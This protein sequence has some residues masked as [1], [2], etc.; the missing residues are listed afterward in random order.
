ML[1]IGQILL[2]GLLVLLDVLLVGY[3]LGIVSVFRKH[4]NSSFAE[5]LIA[6]LAIG[7][8]Y[9]FYQF[10][11][12]CILLLTNKIS[13]VFIFYLKY[14]MD[15]VLMLWVL[16]YKRK[17]IWS[18]YKQILV[19]KN[20][21]IICL[22]TIIFSVLAIINYPYIFL[23][24]QLHWLVYFKSLL[25]GQFNLNNLFNH[26][27]EGAFGFSS[28]LY[29]PALIFSKVPLEYLASGIKLFYGFILGILV[30]FTAERIFKYSRNISAYTLLFLIVFSSMGLFAAYPLGKQTIFGI[31]FSIFYYFSLEKI[32]AYPKDK[33]FY[34]NSAL[35]FATSACLA[36]GVLPYLIFGT[37]IFLVLNKNKLVLSFFIN[38]LLLYSF[39]PLSLNIATGLS[40]ITYS[41]HNRCG[42]SFYQNLFY[43]IGLP[44][45]GLFLFILTGLI[46]L[47][48]FT[49]LAVKWQLKSLKNI[50]GK[51]YWPIAFL[52]LIVAL[53]FML[54]ISEK[55]RPFV[56]SVLNDPNWQLIS[57]LALNANLNWLVI[58][59]GLAGMVLFTLNRDFKKI[60]SL[61]ILALFFLITFICLLY[62][63]R[64]DFLKILNFDQLESL[65]RD[66]PRWY[67]GFIFGLF[68]LICINYCT[69]YL[70]K[71]FKKAN[72]IYVVFCFLLVAVNL[73]T[74]WPRILEFTRPAHFTKILGHKNKYVSRVLTDLSSYKNYKIFYAVDSYF[75][76]EYYTYEP[77][78]K[79]S[80]YFDEKPQLIITT[81]KPI[82]ENKYR[83]NF[84]NRYLQK[85]ITYSEVLIKL[86]NLNNFFKE[87]PAILVTNPDFIK[88]NREFKNYRVKEIMRYEF[89]PDRIYYISN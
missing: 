30:I 74:N 22:L 34:T 61:K 60:D 65:V 42:D 18:G 13:P 32:V 68:S 11:F 25:P 63:F 44:N 78:V 51:N 69:Y 15:L 67:G 73:G 72:C 71:D 5:L 59:L 29:F 66:L 4:K 46:L 24:N 75:F 45:I 57:Y 85:E 77:F 31:I 41:V 12:S 54:P 27:N 86:F 40:F 2:M 48:L 83:I 26:W 55:I 49:K 10:I 53:N 36:I 6:S 8:I 47:I 76:T 52:F 1:V 7:I 70:I 58:I 14:F 37:L 81:N 19:D 20:I 64:I 87:L 16:V 89:T 62:A 39:L 17:N 33:Y 79:F 23:E 28:L 50:S 38:R 56:P 3:T 84:L 88:S 35:L 9:N 80:V 21:L 82:L 43:K